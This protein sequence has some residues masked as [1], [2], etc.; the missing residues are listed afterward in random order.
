MAHT[1]FTFQALIE[2]DP[3][4]VITYPYIMI[5]GQ[6]AAWSA[7]MACPLSTWS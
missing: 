2:N 1:I 6:A 4:I 3:A 5:F 7:R